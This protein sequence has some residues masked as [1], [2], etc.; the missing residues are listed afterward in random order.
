[1]KWFGAEAECHAMPTWPDSRL[2]R[3]KI[4]RSASSQYNHDKLL[5]QRL[6]NVNNR[7]FRLEN[8]PSTGKLRRTVEEID[9]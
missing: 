5:F 6:T 2:K 9:G 1:M 8:V 4:E 7:R 3:C